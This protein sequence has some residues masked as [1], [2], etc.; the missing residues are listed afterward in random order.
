MKKQT[1]KPKKKQ[2]KKPLIFCLKKFFGCHFWYGLLPLI[3]MI[4]AMP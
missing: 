3:N 1:K 2:K 4:N